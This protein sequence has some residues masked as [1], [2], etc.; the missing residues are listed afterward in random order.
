MKGGGRKGVGRKGGER[1]AGERKGGERKKGSVK[2][3]VQ[4]KHKTILKRKQPTKE[5][6]KEEESPGIRCT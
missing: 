5:E 1:K 2:I 3:N 6:V 4:E